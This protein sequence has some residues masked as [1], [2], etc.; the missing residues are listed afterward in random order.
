MPSDSDLQ[1]TVTLPRVSFGCPPVRLCK[2]NAMHPTSH[3]GH[4]LRM[5]ARAATRD[6]PGV[7]S[8]IETMAAA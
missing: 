2:S 6:R 1:Q 5:Q 7:L 3:T 4:A 8:G